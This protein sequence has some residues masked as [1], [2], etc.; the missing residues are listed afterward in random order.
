MFKRETQRVNKEKQKRQDLACTLQSE[1]PYNELNQ[2]KM[3]W[4]N[5]QQMNQSKGNVTYVNSPVGQ[6]TGVPLDFFNVNDPS[7]FKN[8]GS[9]FVQVNPNFRNYENAFP[10]EISNTDK[11]NI[12][13]KM[14]IG[15]GIR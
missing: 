4:L 1:I 3:I 11:Q 9:Q 15:S 2:A 8:N 13:A 12:L 10:E 14:S 6:V 5:Q 7:V